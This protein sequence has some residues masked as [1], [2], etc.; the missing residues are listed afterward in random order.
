MFLRWVLF[1][2]T[3]TTRRTPFVNS[4]IFYTVHNQCASCSIWFHYF[5]FRSDNIWNTKALKPYVHNTQ[6]C[7]HHFCTHSTTQWFSSALECIKPQVI[8]FIWCV[9]RMYLCFEITRHLL[10]VQLSHMILFA[11][12]F[13]RVGFGPILQMGSYEMMAHKENDG[14]L[15]EQKKVKLGYILQALINSI[16][17]WISEQYYNHLLSP[18]MYFSYCNHHFEAWTW[19]RKNSIFVSILLIGWNYPTHLNRAYS[20][21]Q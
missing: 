17:V 21:N 10:C 8:C 9:T 2:F 12:V 6:S 14:V 11:K 5:L 13:I 16:L 1:I 18:K 4:S 19:N 15:G 7:E 3:R 20:K